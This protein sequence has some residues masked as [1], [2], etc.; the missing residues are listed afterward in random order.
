MN[1]Q[2]DNQNSNTLSIDSNMLTSVERLKIEGG[3]TQ[4]QKK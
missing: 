2:L 1:P 4:H 3:T